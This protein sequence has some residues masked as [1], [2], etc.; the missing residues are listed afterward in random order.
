MLGTNVGIV[1]GCCDATPERAGV[2]HGL[3]QPLRPPQQVSREQTATGI[4]S[5][6]RRARSPQSFFFFPSPSNA[7]IAPRNTR[8]DYFARIALPYPSNRHIPSNQIRHVACNQHEPPSRLV[9]PCFPN[10][11]LPTT[12]PPSIHSKCIISCLT[13][14]PSIPVDRE[15][16]ERHPRCHQ[17][18]RQDNRATKRLLRGLLCP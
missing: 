5:F 10:F 2:P 11:N 17:E 8:L 4:H 9:T 15:H 1:F 12:C 16:W 13:T 14:T 18:T 3:P 7:C 6:K